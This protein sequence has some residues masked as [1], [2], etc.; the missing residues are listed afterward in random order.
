MLNCRID[1][2]SSP[3]R[4]PRELD[5]TERDL[6]LWLLPGDRPG[7]AEYRK[8]V[9][10]WSVA[11]VGRRGEGNYILAEPGWKVDNESP[12]PQLFAYGV[13]EHDGGNL[14]VSIRERLGGQIEFE[15]EGQMFA[16]SPEIRRWTF[17]EWAP[18]HP[19]PSCRSTVREVS[20][21]T[22]AGQVLDLVLCSK[23]RRIWVFDSLTGMNALIPVTGFYNELMMQMGVKDPGIALEPQRIFDLSG[24]PSDSN[25]IKALS[26]YNRV[27]KKVA[28]EGTL[29]VA[30]EPKLN[31]LELV[32]GT[33][34]WKRKR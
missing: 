2:M 10:Q 17:S 9:E 31:W 30:V 22:T 13:V 3:E 23:D 25:L 28:I 21:T 14:T 27:R 19:C 26:S 1:G 20:M 34:V 4:L 7:Y 8:F 12:L 5:P 16:A 33:L 32:V 11:A 29:N 18:S 24:G 15:I 6:L